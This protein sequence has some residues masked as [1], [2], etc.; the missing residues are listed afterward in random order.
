M[1]I[2]LKIIIRAFILILKRDKIKLC[3]RCFHISIIISKGVKSQFAYINT[4]K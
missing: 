1:N 2:Y 3:L 4:L